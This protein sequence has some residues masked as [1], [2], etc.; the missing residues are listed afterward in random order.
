MR[1]KCQR[2]SKPATYHITDI[3]GRQA[4]EFHLC[5]EHARQHLA[6]GEVED[7]APLSVEG[8]V[9]GLTQGW[10]P[11]DP[12]SSDSL[13]CPVCQI[14]FLEFR[15]SGRLGCPHD[16]EVFRDDLMPLLEKIHDETR[17]CGKVPRRAPKNS[18][19]QSEL[20][21]KRNQLKRAVESEQFELAAQ[22]RD[23]IK[24]LEEDEGRSST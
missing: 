21:Q 6:A 3:Q 15:N 7:T 17:H 2:C 23:E 11:K 10:A 18:Q 1:E 13:S 12:V 20:I 8:L 22:L 5:D 14:S 24:A 16:Y 9:S 4:K 19:R